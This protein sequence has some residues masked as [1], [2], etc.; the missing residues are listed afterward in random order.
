VIPFLLTRWKAIAAF[1]VL[2]GFAWAWQGWTTE[3]ALRKAD[4][5]AYVAA[6]AEATVIAQR[7]LEATEAEYRNKADEADKAFQSKLADARRAADAYVSAHRVRSQAHQ[8]SPSGTLASAESGRASVPA[9]LPADAVLVSER[10]VQA[11]TH[12]VTYGIEAHDWAL[13]LPK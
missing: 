12:A 1:A 2:L 9:S 10:D 13:T 11:C 7:A 5:A 3:K 6:Q 8:G 4:R